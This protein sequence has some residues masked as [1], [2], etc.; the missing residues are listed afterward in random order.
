MFVR[1]LAAACL[2]LF[3]STAF[4]LCDRSDFDNTLYSIE[5]A[6]LEDISGVQTAGRMTFLTKFNKLGYM[7]AR[8][9]IWG[10]DTYEGSGGVG[11]YGGTAN[12]DKTRL[13]ATKFKRSCYVSLKMEGVSPVNGYAWRLASSGYASM[14]SVVDGAP[15]VVYLH[16]STITYAGS[17]EWAVVV[18]TR[19][20]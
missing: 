20:L 13:S 14:A 6:P 10:Y 18:L 1:L 8:D 12:S 4:A 2:S 15:D 5:I 19:I 16:N 7:R 3:T 17:T 11:I 9:Y